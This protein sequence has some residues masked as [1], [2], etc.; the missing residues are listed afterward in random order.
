MLMQLDHVRIIQRGQ[1]RRLT[2]D[3]SANRAS[4]SRSRLG[5]LIALG[6]R[7]IVPGQHHITETA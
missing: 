3:I 2:T 7:R 5:Y 4:A 1:H 6:A